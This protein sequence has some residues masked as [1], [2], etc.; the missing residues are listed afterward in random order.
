MWHLFEQINQES[1]E[2]RVEVRLAQ[3]KIRL[4]HLH[5]V[6]ESIVFG[7]LKK[8]HEVFQG[9]LVHCCLL[10]TVAVIQ[11]SQAMR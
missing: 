1:V 7:V 4:E 10:V 11:Q 3:Q 5:E 6:D 8:L 9:I 2:E